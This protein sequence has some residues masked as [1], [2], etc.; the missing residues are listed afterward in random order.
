MACKAMAENYVAVE[1]TGELVEALKYA[2]KHHLTTNILGGGSNTLFVDWVP[3]LL[4]HLRTK[5]KK[6]LDSE[7]YPERKVNGRTRLIEVQAGEDWHEFVQWTLQENFRGLENLSLIPGTVGAAPIQNIGAYGVEVESVLEWVHAVHRYSLEEKTFS[8][9]ECC[10]SYRDSIFKHEAKDWI[11]TSVVF[12][13]SQDTPLN[14]GYNE[15]NNQWQALGSPDSAIVLGDLVCKIR[16][17]KL[18]DPSEI[19]NSGSFFKNP[20][21]A[22]DHYRRLKRQFP[23]I[24]AYPLSNQNWKLAAGWLIQHCGWKGYESNGVGVYDKQALVLVNPGLCEGEKVLALANR[25]S[26]SVT[27]KFGVRLEIEPVVSSANDFSF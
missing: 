23:D 14:T 18:P 2:H 24:I 12:R 10:F 25:I 15:L 1:T 17:A 16:K 21:V 5:G 11:I 8:H 20:V 9:E 7:L 3:G 6:L 26:N 27:V 19:P 4:I 22:D 13:L